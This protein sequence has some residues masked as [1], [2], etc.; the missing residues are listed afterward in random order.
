WGAVAPRAR[1]RLESR[2]I[3]I[4]HHAA[5]LPAPDELDFM[6]QAPFSCDAGSPMLLFRFFCFQIVLLGSLA[7]PMSHAFAQREDM[8]IGD[9]PGYFPNAADDGLLLQL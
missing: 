7:V 6:Q 1:G 5:A 4:G 8:S 9:Q 3:S 2:H